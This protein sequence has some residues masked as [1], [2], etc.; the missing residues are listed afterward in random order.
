MTSKNAV[1]IPEYNRYIAPT[2]TLCG[3]IGNMMWRYASMYGLGRQLN[4][5]PFFESSANCMK[6]A[7]KE[8]LATF[9]EHTII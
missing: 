2:V 4:R 1:M 7:Q 5:T 8:A 9:P 3:G 6:D